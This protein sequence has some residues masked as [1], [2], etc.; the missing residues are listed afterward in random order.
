MQTSITA[1]RQTAIPNEAPPGWECETPKYRAVRDI[2]PAEKAR[3]RFE[4]PFVTIFDSDIWQYASQP[5]KSGEIVETKE[6]PHPSFRPLNYSAGKVLD[7]FNS[8]IKSRLPR[9]PWHGDQIRL[10]D[11]LTGPVVGHVPPPQFTPMD[12]RPVS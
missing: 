5:V 7:F 8:R 11:G 4:P 1:N 10:D 2:H 6:W 12:L 3:F 9:S